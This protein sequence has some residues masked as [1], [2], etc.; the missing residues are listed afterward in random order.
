MTNTHKQTKLPQNKQNR[1]DATTSDI[2][3]LSNYGFEKKIDKSAT[4]R[5]FFV[6]QSHQHLSKMLGFKN[7]FFSSFVAGPTPRQEPEVAQVKDK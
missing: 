4:G 7:D 3:K 5:N 1:A 2:A 6:K